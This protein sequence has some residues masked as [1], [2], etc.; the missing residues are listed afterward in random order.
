MASCLRLFW[1]WVRL[2]LSRTFWTAGTSRAIST[3]MMAM[4]TRSSIN[5]NPVVARRRWGFGD[6][7]RIRL[8]RGRGRV[9]PAEGNGLHSRLID[10]HD[11]LKGNVTSQAT[12]G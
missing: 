1:H 12:L 3:A 6:I 2:A 4:T 11:E 7:M 5:V 9:G 10:A 8:R